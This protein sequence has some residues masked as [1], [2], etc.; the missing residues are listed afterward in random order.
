MKNIFSKIVILILVAFL[1]S[2]FAQVDTLTILHMND[3]HSTLTSVGPRN[4]SL[5][6]SQGGIA[7]AAT[8]IGMTRTNDPNVLVLHAGDYSVGDL[9]Y[10]AYFGVPE[11]QILK[12]LGLDAMAVGN[13][14][15]DLTPSTLLG[16]LQAAFPDPADG[17]PLLSANTDLSDPSLTGLKK[18]ILPYTVKQI[19]NI[20]VGIFGMTTP[21]TN[22][23][24]NPSPAVI[25]EDIINISAGMV[26]TLTAQNCD[27]IIMLSHLGLELD[28]VIAANIPGIN[29]IVGG[30]DHYLLT[31]PVA[32]TNPSGK[33]TLIVQAKS[34]YLYLGK[35]KL[36]VNNGNVNLINY[37]AIRLDKSV[38][39]DPAVLA[40]V[41]FLISNIE[42][43]Y[44]I[45]FYTQQAGY[46]ESYFEETAADLLSAGAHDTP[47]G[48]LVA[49]A[50][51]WKTGTDIA[52]QAG[53]FTAMPLYKGPFVPADL[54]RIN[55]Y[56]FN[57]V[58]TL[59]FQLATF[60]LTGADLLAGLEF[61]LSNIEANDEYFMQ[62][63]GMEYTY[64]GNLS[65][66]SRLT[67]VK[68]NGNSI[69]PN[70][71]YTVTAN[72]G[73]LLFLNYL[74]IPVNDLKIL[75]GVTEFQALSEYI[76]TTGTDIYPKVLGRI[77]DI[78][79]NAGGQYAAGEGWFEFPSG[80]LFLNSKNDGKMHFNFEVN[81]LKR[82]HDFDVSFFTTKG[83]FDFKA[84]SFD[85]LTTENNTAQFK[86]SGKVNG[87]SGYGFLIT[88]SEGD[89]GKDKIRAVIWD[90]TNGDRL[91]FDNFSLQN[92]HGNISVRQSKHNG[93]FEKEVAAVDNPRVLLRN[94]PNPFNP[95]TTIHYEIPVDGLVV[96]KVYDVLGREVKT[97]VDDYRSKGSYNVLFNASDLASGIYIYRLSSGNSISVKKMLLMK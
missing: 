13:H 22:V 31:E 43:T 35:L 26:S 52:I 70:A 29:V 85:W 84:N 48:N 16:A 37:K 65:P 5:E 56:G 38:P 27:V 81:T 45:P 90:K 4:G 20:K 23:I 61:G 49:D 47:I 21:E 88:A 53:G 64:D 34:N 74:G 60:K 6:G 59:G 2:S 67:S 87:K 46:A 8:I 11:L 76:Q 57:T 89:K 80:A 9:F 24:S 42:T 19:G 77:A 97:L 68:V 54:F 28:K 93:K 33:T 62:V 14:E 44:G 75:E 30:H 71:V 82:G 95:S 15:W 83:K 91:V 69:D 73:S 1:T 92:I 94:Y 96:L 3:T 66:F 10:N 78:N 17:F 32:V 72:E 58:N 25:S 79:S 7:R 18:Y 86:G 36:A 50:F 55:G 63:S 39:E 40:Q 12:S 51:R 41:N